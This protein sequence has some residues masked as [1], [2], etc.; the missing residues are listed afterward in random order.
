M[1]KLLISLMLVCGTAQAQY[2]DGNSLHTDLSSG[3]SNL[4]M[5]A[6]GYIVGVADVSLAAEVLCMPVDVTQ[7]QIQDVVGNF[8]VANPQ[9]RN[10]P[11]YLLVQ[12]SLGKYWACP[13][14]PKRKKS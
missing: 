8:L 9:A 7:G 6:L 5:Y 3:K 12:V 10:L 13:D 11:A 2:V 14:S 1:K 4:K